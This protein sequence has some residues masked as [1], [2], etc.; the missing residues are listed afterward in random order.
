MSPVPGAEDIERKYEY[1]IDFGAKEER[2]RILDAITYL[3]Q[4]NTLSQDQCD[5]LIVIIK[6]ENK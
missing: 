6:G 1:W 5:N 3:G 2:E 4:T